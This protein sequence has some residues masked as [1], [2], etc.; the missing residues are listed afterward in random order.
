VIRNGC[1]WIGVL[2]IA[3]SVAA[4]PF[5][6]WV[7]NDWGLVTATWG[8]LGLV[9]LAVGLTGRRRADYDAGDEPSDR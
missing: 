6:V 2:L 8:L 9:F 7:S 3:G 5:M 1:K 4:L